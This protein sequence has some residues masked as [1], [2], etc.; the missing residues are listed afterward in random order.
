MLMAGG[1]QSNK[2]YIQEYVG[3]CPYCGFH[4]QRPKTD[5]CSECGNTL[6]ITLKSP[7]KLTGWFLMFVGICSSIA[8]YVTHIVFNLMGGYAS[9]GNVAW[10]LVVPKSI[11]LA[12]LLFAAFVWFYMYR[13]FFERKP[14]TKWIAGAIGC[15][16]PLVLYQ[17]MIWGIYW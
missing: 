5:R 17:I 9:G 3:P 12:V 1:E 14:M 6:E 13:W 11:I 16:L 15:L 7:F 10:K 2:K 8:I 4:L